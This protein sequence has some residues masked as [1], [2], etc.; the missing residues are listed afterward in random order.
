M[1]APYYIVS[2]NHFCM[3]ESKF[4]QER[5]TKLFNIFEKIKQTGGTLI[6]GGDFFDY[7]FEYDE[8]IPKGYENIL[9]SFCEMSQNNI[10]IHYVL[11]NHDYWDFGYLSKHC[12]VKTHNGD[13]VIKHND[14]NILITHGDGLLKNDYGYRFMKKIIRSSI[15]IKLYKAFPPSFT[16]KIA[17]KTSQISSRYNH[18]DDYVKQIKK[19][20]LLYAKKKW[21]EN[22]NMVLVGHYHQTGSINEQN[23]SLTFL[24]DWISKFTVTKI[25]DNGIWQGDWKEFLDL[26]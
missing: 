15:F 7:W 20:I 21:K 26:S 13:L 9:D 2:D 8:V 12:N 16:I 4:E 17:N 6:I 24:G 22:F 23:N 3:D 25:D 18:H 1:K 10:D 11:G 5:R 19:E 14:N